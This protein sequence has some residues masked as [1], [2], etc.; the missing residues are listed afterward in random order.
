MTKSAVNCYCLQ[1]SQIVEQDSVLVC[2]GHV[3]IIDTSVAGW[4]IAE[5][6]GT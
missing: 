6:Q 1:K 5:E 4:Q 2:H 3:I